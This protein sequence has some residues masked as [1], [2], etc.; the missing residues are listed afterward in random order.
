MGTRVLTRSRAGHSCA[1]RIPF[2]HASADT[3]PVLD[4]RVLTRHRAGHSLADTLLTKCGAGQTQI[5][6]LPAEIGLLTNLTDLVLT[7]NK[8]SYLPDQI[9]DLP[10]LDYLVRGFRI[11]GLEFQLDGWKLS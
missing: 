11:Y 3:R 7:Y 5:S 6:K 1:D 10:R 9:G 8:L 2:G 4:T